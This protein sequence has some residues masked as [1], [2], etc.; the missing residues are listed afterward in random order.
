VSPEAHPPDHAEDGTSLRSL[1]DVRRFVIKEPEHV[2]ER[3]S[4]QRAAELLLRAAEDA[5]QV[6]AATKT[7]R[8]PIGF[9]GR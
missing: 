7:S 2:Q 6:E 8:N 3:S 4:W 5:S 1:A 9:T